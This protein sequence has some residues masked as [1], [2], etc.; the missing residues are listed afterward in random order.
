MAYM[1]RY[2]KKAAQE[3]CGKLGKLLVSGEFAV[4]LVV[5]AILIRLLVPES[6]VFFRKL[7]I[8]GMPDAA[9][10]S[11]SE[12]MLNIRD[13]MGISQAVEAFCYDIFE[14]ERP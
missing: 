9:A 3:S 10:E 14:D 1:I 8:P 2:G 11:F 4:S 13:G 7:L 12:M 5:I 6:G